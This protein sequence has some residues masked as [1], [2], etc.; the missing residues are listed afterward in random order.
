MYS[1]QALWSQNNRNNDVMA[2]QH[3]VGE[4]SGGRHIAIHCKLSWVLSDKILPLGAGGSVLLLN[5][6][7]RHSIS[8]K[9]NREIRME[10]TNL[11]LSSFLP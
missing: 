3:V 5:V 10:T 1:L 2:F 9:L 7:Q 8:S 4:A 6:L 11:E